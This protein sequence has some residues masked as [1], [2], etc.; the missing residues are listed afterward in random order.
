MSDMSTVPPILQ[1][2]IPKMTANM[3]FVSVFYIIVGVLYSLTIIG[4]IVGIPLIISGLC[5]KESTDAFTN[6]AYSNQPQLLE[7]A[8][9]RQNSFFF[10][11]KSI[12]EI[13]LAIFLLIIIFIVVFGIA[14]MNRIGNS[15]FSVMLYNSTI[16]FLT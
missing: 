13:I 6:F 14:I 8:L 16:N 4:A 7:A 11:T 15:E 2:L 9:E 10:H 12:H 3:R 5:L 1:I